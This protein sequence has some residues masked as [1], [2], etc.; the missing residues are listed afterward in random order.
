MMISIHAPRG[1]SDTQAI[2]LDRNIYNFNPRSP[3][4]ERLGGLVITPT[5][6]V[7]QSTLPVGGA[8]NEAL[9]QA[10]ESG[11]SIHAPRGGSDQIS[12]CCCNAEKI[13]QSTLP[14]GGATAGVFYQ[15]FILGISIHAPRGGSD[16]KGFSVSVLKGIFQSTLPVGGATQPKLIDIKASTDFNP[17]SP[18]GERPFRPV[19]YGS[20]LLI[21]IHAP[22]GGS[23]QN[24][25]EV[26][27]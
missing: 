23:D 8:T 7:F 4:G 1:G 25:F 9:A 15:R 13:F 27:S 19:A 11:I 5:R 21:S 26:S 24:I 2:R 22:R 17:R 16:R 12:D 3:W 18:W 6:T 14:V 10:K 20:D